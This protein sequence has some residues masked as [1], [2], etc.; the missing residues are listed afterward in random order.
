[1][2][3]VEVVLEAD[4]LSARAANSPDVRR[5]LRSFAR[6]ECANNSY[7]NG[8]ILTIANELIGRGPRL[9]MHLPDSREA[10]RR[11]E[12]AFSS[13][14][15]ASGLNDQ[16]HTMAQAVARDGE[17]CAVM[18]HNQGINDRVR[19]G[20]RL[21]EAEQLCAPWSASYKDAL[22]DGI[23]FDRFGNPVAYNILRHH[24]GDYGSWDTDKSDTISAEFFLHWFR[25]DRPGQV[26]GV[27]W[28][29]PCLGLFAQLRRWTLAV[30]Q[31][32]ETAA[33]FSAIL[34]TSGTPETTAQADPWDGV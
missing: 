25:E 2:I 3:V 33:S 8:I 22:S 21:I 20:I 18:I 32:A 31:S 27:P 7:A 30:L 24:P 15:A 34:K 12:K 23:R 10:N 26:R 16:L 13:W 5:R 29:T 11:I 1:M 28:I 9:Q 14:Q 19:T 17:A 4:T 6:Y